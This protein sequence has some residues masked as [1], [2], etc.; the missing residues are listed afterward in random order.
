MQLDAL[1]QTLSPDEMDHIDDR[2]LVEAKLASRDL[3][4]LM[5]SEDV[6]KQRKDQRAQEA[7]RQAEQQNRAME[8]QIDNTKADTF[9]AVSQGQKNAAGADKVSVDTA[10][11]M[12]TGSEDGKPEAGTKRAGGKAPR[13]S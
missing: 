4:G 12:I 5:V 11:A 1:N 3:K 9:K 7:A 8:A 10:M 2:K 6:A 13:R